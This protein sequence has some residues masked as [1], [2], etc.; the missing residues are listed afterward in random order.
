MNS[1]DIAL[2]PEPYQI[3]GFLY[4]IIRPINSFLSEFIH[5]KHTKI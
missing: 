5:L 3:A 4:Q 2:S 1:G